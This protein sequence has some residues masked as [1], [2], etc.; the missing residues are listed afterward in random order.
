MSQAMLPQE[1]EVLGLAKE[2][3]WVKAAKASLTDITSPTSEHW[4]EGL[5]SGADAYF[6]HVC[7]SPLLW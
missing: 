2:R 5:V 7:Y 4:Q 1:A 6:W 3:R